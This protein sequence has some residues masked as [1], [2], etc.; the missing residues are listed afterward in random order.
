MEISLARR[1]IHRASRAG[2]TFIR[3][4]AENTAV[5]LMYHRVNVPTSDTDHL[6]VSPSRF[7]EQMRALRAHFDPVPLQA[8]DER[9]SYRASRGRKRRV[10]VTFDDGY[11]DTLHGA[12]PALRESE[13]PATVFVTTGMVGRRGEFWWDELRQLVIT[14]HHKQDHEALHAR[15]CRTLREA[16]SEAIESVLTELRRD[17]QRPESNRASH[18]ALRLDELCEL[19]TD[20]LIEIGAHTVNH[21]CLG[22]LTRTAQHHEIRESRDFLE[23]SL[24]RK[25]TSFAYPYGD[26]RSI[27]QD[28]LELTRDLGF[29]VALSTLDG[30]VTRGSARYALPRMMARDW[31]GEDFAARVA[32]Y[33]WMA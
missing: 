33:F 2:R 24:G 27:N 22:R 18:R 14:R 8:L 31:S 20:P 19:G 21:A 28:S 30:V 23:K 15:L 12:L 16:G 17:T 26:A 7:R 9:Q 10:A 4:A 6:A 32:R 29:R 1:A 13:I 25:I 5:I 3:T 11:A